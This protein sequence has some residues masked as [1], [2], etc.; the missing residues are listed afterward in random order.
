MNI[1]AH[2]TFKGDAICGADLTGKSPDGRPFCDDCMGV[3]FDWLAAHDIDTAHAVALE[4]EAI[5]AWLKRLVA[6]EREQA[7][8]KDIASGLALACHHEV[9]GLE[10]AAHAIES[11]EHNKPLPHIAREGY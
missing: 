2:V 8:R 5:V 6:A 9:M 1:K 3:M 7:D 10:R 4:R 11:G